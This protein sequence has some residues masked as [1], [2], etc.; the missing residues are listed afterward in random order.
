MS[1]F[2]NP[3][4][5]I[6]NV[7]PILYN[8]A[9]QED[10][11]A[12]TNLS[13]YFKSVSNITYRGENLEAVK[14]RAAQDVTN[15]NRAGAPVIAPPTNTL[16]SNGD[17]L[18]EMVYVDVYRGPTN[19]APKEL[20]AAI[21]ESIQIPFSGVS[22]QDISKNHSAMQDYMLTIMLSVGKKM[23]SKAIDVVPKNNLN[24][25]I[26]WNQSQF[27][28][29]TLPLSKMN[30]LFDDLAM[31]SYTSLRTIIKNR[32]EA[33][34]EY[35]EVPGHT[36]KTLPL[37]FINDLRMGADGFKGPLYYSLKQTMNET[38]T[39]NQRVINYDNIH[40]LNYF[41]MTAID[42]YIKLCY[43][44]ILYVYITSMMEI[45]T[46]KG[47]FV[48]ARLALLASI[49]LTLKF[50][51]QI[52]TE[53]KNTNDTEYT[54]A[55]TNIFNMLKFYLQNVNTLMNV[56]NTDIY[57]NVINDLHRTS[58]SVVDV[59]KSVQK[60]QKDIRQN[61]LALR[62]V[63]YNTEELKKQYANK[64]AEFG[65]MI[66]LLL[67]LIIG[68]STLMLLSTDENKF[69]MYVLY[70]AGFFAVGILIYEVVKIIS[71]LIASGKKSS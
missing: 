10:T 30:M 69:K 62:N 43:P 66:F 64:L 14:A 16:G 41:K 26:P 23:V 57:T 28:L 8:L 25:A 13:E 12:I 42:Y 63:I 38:Y 35:N 6:Y 65:V 7:D 55:I 3:N 47:D 15:F 51:N 5:Q 18:A 61:Q 49:M 59:N 71:K 2:I 60:L 40:V 39:L 4:S 24:N 19:V 1:E 32:V 48:N 9:T 70:V 52:S 58:T 17:S 50:F 29:V 37:D 68:C 22:Q 56:E 67:V 34:K 36:K 11:S 33:N 45:Y 54:A 31:N 44:V 21:M 53:Y 27:A 46:E 20:I